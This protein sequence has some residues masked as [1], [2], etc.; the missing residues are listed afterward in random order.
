ML[1]PYQS[2]LQLP[3]A[4]LEN[5]IKEFLLTQMEDGSFVTMDDH[6]MSIAIAQCKQ[7]LSRS[8]LVVEYSE[9]DESIAIRHKDNTLAQHP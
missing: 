9:D 7:A 8:E 2:L 4:T 3:Q 1:V 6:A 5:L